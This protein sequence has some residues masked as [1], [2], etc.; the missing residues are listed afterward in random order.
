[1]N[2]SIKLKAEKASNQS[3]HNFEGHNFSN[4]TGDINRGKKIQR[5]INLLIEIHFCINIVFKVL[6]SDIFD[7]LN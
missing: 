7:I 2:S 1:M 6:P 5:S 3:N 4:E